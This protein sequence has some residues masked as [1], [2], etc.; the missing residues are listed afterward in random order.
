M[1]SFFRSKR[2]FNLTLAGFSFVAIGIAILYFQNY[3]WLEPCPYCILQRLAFGFLG[4]LFLVAGIH[5]PKGWG[6]KVYA[7][8]IGVATMLG[9]FLSGKHSWLQL[10]HSDELDSCRQ[11]T[12]QIEEFLD[13]DFIRE[14]LFARGDCT[15]IDL[16]LFGL[17]IPM[18]TFLAFLVIGG[19]GIVYN[20][21][22]W[23]RP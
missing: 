20:W 15:K 16:E 3:L 22:E 19:A 1:R 17:S 23:K 5:H 8:L 13:F 11:T 7:G 12:M 4:G 18:W 9:L 6:A 2:W 14:L 21:I 10:N